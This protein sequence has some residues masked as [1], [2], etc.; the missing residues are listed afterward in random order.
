MAAP[1][2]RWALANAAVAAL[3][4]DPNGLYGITV[5]DRPGPVRDALI[6]CLTELLDLPVARLPGGMDA[7]ALTSGTDLVETI[8]T[9]RRIERGGLLTRQR[10][11]LMLVPMSERMDAGVAAQIASS[12]DEAKAPVLI[13][14]DEG[15]EPDESA[16]PA[17]TD[18]LAMTLA[19]EGV[20]RLETGGV[21]YSR[22]DVRRA[23]DRYDQG[24]ADGNA[25]EVILSLASAMGIGSLRA[26]LLALRLAR[27]LTALDGAQEIGEPQI[28]TATA[29]CL[30]PRAVTL[31]SAEDAP[32]DAPPP[33]EP[34][35]SGQAKSTEE[36][37]IEDK[38]LD[39]VAA[40]LPELGLLAGQARGQSR[41]RGAGDRQRSA[42]HGR[43]ARSRTGKPEGRRLDVFA[44]LLAAAPWQTV[45][46]RTGS[47]RDGL[48]VHTD[49][50]RIKQYERPSESV[51]IF[52]V[53]ASGSQAAARMAEAKGAVELML[54]EAYRRREK[55]AL[56]SFRGRGAEL[57]LPPTRSLLQA[58]R[59]LA[60][61]PGGGPTP[62]ATAL[63]AGRELATKIRRGGAT[64]YLVLLTD[65][66]GNIGLDGE[67]GRKQA[68]EDATNAARAIAAEGLTTVLIDTANRPQ[69]DA[70]D[71]AKAMEAKY[72]PLPR[73]DAK[74]I[75]KMVRSS[76]E[77]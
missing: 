64:P 58:K 15:V 17:V 55:V 71:L 35:D 20:S 57:L 69:Q 23:R 47:P 70:K 60:V 59:R 50:F 8:R 46:Q 41:A 12:I 14:L 63:V 44:T 77:Q 43:P 3:A 67:P 27:V 13:L 16:P 4:V 5:R 33:P 31:P 39:A 72:L 37:Q 25:P 49:D 56:I 36:G 65:G 42:T 73:A 29:L 21:F 62:L 30:A 22:D 34:D 40:L 68:A 74:A 45:R 26:P 52:L 66:R 76:V 53:D 2:D 11:T 10:E 48:I 19:L 75:S 24:I 6:A 18:R 54:S 32:E 7:S 9:G 61:M 38:V 28:I 51:L 1:G